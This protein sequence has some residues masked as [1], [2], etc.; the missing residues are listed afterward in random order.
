MKYMMK[1][2]SDKITA[3]FLYL[4]LAE[5]VVALLLA[6]D[7][8]VDY[9]F[10][11]EDCDTYAIQETYRVKTGED[12]EKM[13]HGL[14]ML[15]SGED[16]SALLHSYSKATSNVVMIAQD[17]N[18]N[19]LLDTSAQDGGFDPASGVAYSVYRPFTVCNA[20]GQ[21]TE[22]V[23][24][25]YLRA[26]LPARDSY[27][28]AAS[29]VN[30]ANVVKY[31]ILVLLALFILLSI[32]VLGVIM[33]SVSRKDG[34]NQSAAPERFIDKIPFDLLLMLM[35]LIMAFV[36]LLIVLTSVADIKQTN[37][38]LWNAVILLLAFI[39]SA[40][41]LLFVI[42]LA[43]RIKYGHV[44]RNTLIYKLIAAIR[45]KNPGKKDKGDFKVRFISKVLI[46]IIALVT[47]E[48][49]LTLI[50]L[51]QYKT[52]QNGPLSE[53]KFTY[54]AI[55][56][57]IVVSIIGSLFYMMIVNIHQLRVSSKKLAEGKLDET[58]DAA[59]VLFGDFKEISDDFV[60]IK[61]DILEAMQ[62]KQ[63]SA[64]MRNELIANISHDIKTP[65][66]SIINYADLVSSGGCSEEELR[67]YLGVISHQ[68]ER[69]NDLLQSL[70]DVSKL[71][72]GTVK[73]TFESLDIGLYLSQVLE[74]FAP[75]FA[76]KQLEPEVVFPDQSLLVRCDS[77]MLWRVFQNLL[78]NICKYAMPQTRVY[79][80]IEKRGEYA[81]VSFK[82]TSA[83]R[84]TLSEEELIQRFRRNDKARTSS[85]NGLG[86]SIAKQFTELQEGTFDLR[87]DGDLFKTEL[88]FR[89]S[90]PAP[91]T[92][93]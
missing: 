64:E 62:E 18:G 86:I 16:V 66:T 15:L 61:G 91:E 36:T 81:A 85:G 75:A 28:L 83:Q 93:A 65:L 77:S 7:C 45:K 70:I 44:Y 76:E 72:T 57:L 92:E 32:L 42:S 29:L 23:I 5:I 54:F 11:A 82:N 47:F 74:E 17:A 35:A 48:V 38:V 88:L 24:H 89:L 58:E 78:Q 63:R 14:T 3:I 73:A 13:E 30:M 84:I 12:F 31:P 90:E 71:S 46:T 4:L 9:H 40:I 6:I 22:G 79:M 60:S 34:K 19:V 37:L 26:G 67:N 21:T 53:F 41:M 10:Y 80:E 69:L 87:V 55:V 39:I 51:F 50:F 49:L 68:S 27:H 59:A 1:N 43:T 33:S 25:L 2:L 52:H 8:M 20:D 56:Q